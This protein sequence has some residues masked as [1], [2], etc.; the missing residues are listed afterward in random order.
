MLAWFIWLLSGKGNATLRQFYKL[1]IA[2]D[3]YQSVR[4]Y[5]IIQSFML[6]TAL[7]KFLGLW[8]AIDC[9]TIF[10]LGNYDSWNSFC[11]FMWSKPETACLID[12]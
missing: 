7:K 12:G 6:F 10:S 11:K 3:A 2:V 5:A 8:I 9:Y 4:Y 1:P